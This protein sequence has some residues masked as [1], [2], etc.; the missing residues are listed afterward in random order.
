LDEQGRSFEGYELKLNSY[1]LGVDIELHDA[2]RSSGI[3]VDSGT[4]G[5]REPRRLSPPVE[6]LLRRSISARLSTLALWSVERYSPV[7]LSA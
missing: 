3:L 6:A 2:F 1:D 7:R 5:D 4:V